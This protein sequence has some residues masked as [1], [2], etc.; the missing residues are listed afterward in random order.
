MD[1]EQAAAA[2]TATKGSPYASE[3]KSKVSS[4]KLRNLSSIEPILQHKK[5]KS[6]ANFYSKFKMLTIYEAF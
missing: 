3:E 4:L 1:K 6:T 2:L 5:L